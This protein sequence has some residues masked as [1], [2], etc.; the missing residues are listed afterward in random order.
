MEIVVVFPCMDQ[1][2]IKEFRK[3]LEF[4]LKKIEI[5]CRLW[6]PNRRNRV[7]TTSVESHNR[8]SIS[9]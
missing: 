3:I 2:F 8:C 7:D 4:F 1:R 6:A 9:S 5:L